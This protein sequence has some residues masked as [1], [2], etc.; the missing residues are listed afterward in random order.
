M[1]D[2]H[3]L[4]AL[5]GDRYALGVEWVRE[6][7]RSSPVTPLPGAPRTVAGVLNVRGEII[8]ALETSEILAR[9]ER[10]R[11]GPVVVVEAGGR[12]VGLTVDE[13]VDVVPVPLGLE[14]RD[15]PSL[16]GSALI[17][18]ALIGVLDVPALLDGVGAGAGR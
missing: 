9:A 11:P 14:P 15:D 18:G 10:G 7:L 17:D 12:R 13:L 1:N 6:A 16:L 2:L 4:V 8:P 5:G 3:L